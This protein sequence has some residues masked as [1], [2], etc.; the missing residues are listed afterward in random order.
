MQTGIFK[1]EDVLPGFSWAHSFQSV[2]MLQGDFF[3]RFYGSVR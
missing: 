3:E 2:E 1:E